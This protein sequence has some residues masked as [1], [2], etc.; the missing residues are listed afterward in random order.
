MGQ[1][2]RFV[3]S[4]PHLIVIA[5]AVGFSILSKV[6]SALH[7]Q[8]KRRK[9][10]EEAQLR[11]LEALRTGRAVAPPPVAPV[12]PAPQPDRARDLA[13]RRRAMLAA[14]EQRRAR[15]AA[16]RAPQPAEAVRQLI[17]ALG[18]PVA[19]PTQPASVQ[20]APIDR[21]RVAGASARGDVA[22]RRRQLEQRLAAQR[23]RA[24]AVTEDDATPQRLVAD[25]PAYHAAPTARPVP[26][27]AGQRLDREGLR[28][29]ILAREIL[30][31]PLALRATTP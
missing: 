6:A 30:D 25:V 28:R 10:A 16:G 18:V 2:W 21:P 31:P 12:R 15:A 4:N 13:E 8:S 26:V 5:L 14:M 7:E 3:S 1:L 9:A 24:A 19:A 22:S 17:G 23:S 11:E 20:A 29:M 27:L